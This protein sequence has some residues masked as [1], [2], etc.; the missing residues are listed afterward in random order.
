MS[1]GAPTVLSAPSFFL[2]RRDILPRAV[3]EDLTSPD[4]GTGA[5]KVPGSPSPSP[6]LYPPPQ[7]LRALNLPPCLHRHTHDRTR[8]CMPRSQTAWYGGE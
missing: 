7:R 3:G 6:L 4:G 5:P 1:V 2:S 8:R